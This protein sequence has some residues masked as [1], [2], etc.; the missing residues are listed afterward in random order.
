MGGVMD[1]IQFLKNGLLSIA[2]PIVEPRSYV[3][4]KS[5]GFSGME[6]LSGDTRIIG[7]DMGKAIK[8][9]GGKQP[10]TRASA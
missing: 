5:R 4:P 10:H 2:D 3:Y 1:I 6:K 9:Y 8:K 7:D